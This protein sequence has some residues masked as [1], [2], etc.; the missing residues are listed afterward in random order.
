MNGNHALIN[1][2]KYHYYCF[3]VKQHYS[4]KQFGPDIRTLKCT[5]IYKRIF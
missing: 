1:S 3:V 5:K 2:A 4:P